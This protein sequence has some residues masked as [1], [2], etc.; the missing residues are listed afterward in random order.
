MAVTP[1]VVRGLRGGTSA[2][3]LDTEDGRAFLQQRVAFFNKIAFSISGAFHADT[4]RRR[5][6]GSCASCATTR[7]I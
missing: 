2:L 7:A 5:E 3:D 4:M 6:V 1:R